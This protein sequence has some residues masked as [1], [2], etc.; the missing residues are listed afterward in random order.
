VPR[1]NCPTVLLGVWKLETNMWDGEVMA[2]PFPT[3]FSED[4]KASEDGLNGKI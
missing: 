4:M 3:L 1:D 2:G